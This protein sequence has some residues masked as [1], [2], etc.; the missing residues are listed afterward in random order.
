MPYYCPTAQYAGA[1]VCLDCA[2]GYGVSDPLF[3]SDAKCVQ[4]E[5]GFFSTGGADEC[6][7]CEYS[8]LPGAATCAPDFNAYNKVTT[9]AGTPK[10][11]GI[12]DGVLSVAQFNYPMAVEIAWKQSVA[13]SDTAN[14]VIRLIIPDGHN[15]FTYTKTIAGTWNVLNYQ[16]LDALNTFGAYSDGIA[17][18]ARFNRPMGLSFNRQKQVLYVADKENHAVRMIKIDATHPDVEWMYT[19][20]TLGNSAIERVAGKVD[21]VM[22]NALFKYPTGL[23][24]DA[25]SSMLYVAD[26]GNNVIRAIYTEKGTVVTVS[27]NGAAGSKDGV[28]TSA[29]WLTPT[30]IAGGKGLNLAVAS[31]NQIRKLVR[32]PLPLVE[33]PISEGAKSMTWSGIT[34]GGY[35]NTDDDNTVANASLSM[36]RNPRGIIYDFSE[37]DGKNE[38]GTL[39]IAD[40]KN[41][42]LRRLYPSGMSKTICGGDPNDPDDGVKNI[43][44]TQ[45]RNADT[46]DGARFRQPSDIAMMKNSNL[47]VADSLNHI[48]RIVHLHD[49]YYGDCERGWYRPTSEAVG[50]KKAPVGYFSPH[51][52]NNVLYACA[53][54]LTEGNWYCP[55]DKWPK[56]DEWGYETDQWGGCPDQMGMVLPEWNPIITETNYWDFYGTCKQCVFNTYSPGGFNACTMCPRDIRAE[57]REFEPAGPSAAWSTWSQKDANTHNNLANRFSEDF[58]TESESL[59]GRMRT[60]FR[61]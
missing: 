30:N 22:S 14:H 48:I 1:A 33:F 40:S 15:G 50:C 26:Q 36:Y 42:V 44:R 41:N 58:S 51:K 11:A 18:L 39:I 3:G 53:G 55:L 21:G 20:K 8:L 24:F 13:V 16:N 43:N 45:Y 29:Q 5:S 35:K 10:E 9:F 7:P 12:R 57:L 38:S 2:P 60:C 31:G 52:G 4:C 6:S 34:I 61:G 37:H 54:A 49:D 25:D 17:T 27:G 28:G 47:L 32:Y 59:D 46:C 56:L 19:T 23:Y